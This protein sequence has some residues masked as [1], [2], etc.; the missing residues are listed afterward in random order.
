[1]RPLGVIPMLIAVDEE[2]GA[3]LFKV[4]PAGYY[5]GYKAAAVGAK[6]TEAVNF[7]EKKVKAVPAEGLGYDA[8]VTAAIAALQSVLAED[9][10]AG[11]IEVGVA[12][13][14]PGHEG[15]SFCVLGADEVEAFLQA[16]AE[17]D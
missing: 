5:V 9:F 7:L 17:R 6:E 4:D 16:I 12:R 2:R 14:G 13:G 8:T 3:S 1:M 11:E 15:R 10:K